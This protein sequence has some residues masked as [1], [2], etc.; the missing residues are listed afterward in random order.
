MSRHLAAQLMTATFALIAGCASGS[1][2]GSI[3]TSR[4][5]EER[6]SLDSPGGGDLMLRL[7]HDVSGYTDTVAVASG[8]A[9]AA[10]MRAY[11]TIGLA[12]TASDPSK[13]LLASGPLR[14][15]RRLGGQALSQ[16]LDCGSSLTGDNA[17]QYEITLRVASEI[18]PAGAQSI[19]RSQ[20]TATAVAVGSSNS[21][22]RC[23]SKL[24]LERRIARLVAGGS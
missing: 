7:T 20:V 16:Y 9:W 5:V 15:H 23:S 19:V 8:P 18:E 21:P 3:P 13:R 12:I 2:G 22:M 4:T 1:G 11:G 6:V 17:D 14:V 24:N 10:L